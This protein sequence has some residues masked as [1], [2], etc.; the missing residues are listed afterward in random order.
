MWMQLD[1]SRVTKTY[2]VTFLKRIAPAKYT[3]TEQEDWVGSRDV[4]RALPAPVISDGYIKFT[5]NVE[6]E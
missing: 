6:A 4:I 1:Q 2:I 3:S 5:T